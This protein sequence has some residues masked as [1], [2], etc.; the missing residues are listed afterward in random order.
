MQFI[1][2]ILTLII[3][4]LIFIG[5]S[6]LWLLYHT[7]NS[8]KKTVRSLTRVFKKVLRTLKKTAV[9]IAK[10]TYKTLRVIAFLPY[11]VVRIGLYLLIKPFTLLK[12]P[13][14][15]VKKPSYRRYTPKPIKIFPYSFFTK[16][17][18]FIAG[19]IFSFVFFFIPLL[20]LVFVQQLPN[21]KSISVSGIS[22]T[23][24]I[25]DRN[26]TLLYQIYANQNRTVVPLDS[27][28]QKLQQ[29]T[30]AIE[31]SDFYDHLGF[32]LKAIIRSAVENLSG[33]ELQG[34][35]TITQ[36]LIKSTLLT[37][38]TTFSRKLKEV[39]LAFW[40]ERIY[41]KRQILELYFNQIPYGGTAWGVQAASEVYFGKDVKDITLA[42]SAF[43]AGIPRAPSIY[44][45]YSSTPTVWKKRQKDVLRRMAELGYITKQEEQEALTTELTFRP[46]QIPIYA[47][48]FVMYVKEL[49]IK[50]YGLPM[51]EKGGLHVVTS[52]D[53][54]MQDMAQKIVSD[55]VNRD[56]YLNL[57]NGAALITNPQNGDILAMVG[58]KDFSDPHIGNVNLTTSRRQPGSSIKVVT[59]S[60]AL[61][62][63]T[64]AASVIDDSPITYVIPGS[65]PYAPV[66]YDGKFHGRVTVRSALANSYNIPAVKTL[67]HLGVPTMVEYA[68]KMG[69]TSWGE[70]SNYGLSITL[71]AA[72]AT[73]IDMATVFGTLANGGERVNTNP[74]LKV[75]DYVGNTIEQKNAQKIRVLDEG[76]AF[77]M[78]DILADNQARSQAF[79]SNSILNI[80]G[81]KVSVKTGTSDNKRD[82]WTIGYTPSYVVAS[83]VGN[84]DNAPMSQHLASGITGAAPIWSKIMTT[85]LKGT[86][87]ETR[88]IPVQVVQKPCLGRTEYFLRGTENTVNCVYI[89]RPLTPKPKKEDG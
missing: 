49:L 89:P 16:F 39:I 31:D 43:L 69:V 67:N 64:T 40:A 83:W 35:S 78:S 7:T 58:S 23:T 14:I 33:N 70:A 18:Y 10:T 25:F 57:T 50:R 81:H 28:P 84:N 9:F 36:Q 6:V 71:G 22:Q 51:V 8:A 75:T 55:E 77:I 73:M 21:P 29:A 27:I 2:D 60:A 20:V 82:N 62:N 85:L 46:P 37:P 45:P 61:S 63:G 66:N 4:V 72:E 76:V 34:G 65:T 52:L 59:Y 88:S 86:P 47:P 13:P 44:S 11:A 42:E 48:H 17:K 15:T 12:R 38:E 79:G 30:I 54:K 5:D 53:L 26:N 1:I 19:G 32:D 24:K 87:P 68:K 74:I 41:T 80:P 56:A 3:V